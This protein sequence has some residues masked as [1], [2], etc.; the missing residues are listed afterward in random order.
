MK[1]FKISK[2]LIEEY[3]SDGITQ[4]NSTTAHCSYC[5][6][7]FKYFSKG[8]YDKSLVKRHLVS[9]G[10]FR[11]KLD[12]KLKIDKPQ[13][14]MDKNSKLKEIY[15]DI[16]L[17]FVGTNIPFA[18]LD[19]PL[20]KQFIKKYKYFANKLNLTVQN[21]TIRSLFLFMIVPFVSCL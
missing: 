15:T 6:K 17:L 9:D 12:E 10:H 16:T 19:H 3:E 14:K 11:K 5:H 4:V 1:K 18:K 21:A 13:L 20:W 2:N 8:R 7:S